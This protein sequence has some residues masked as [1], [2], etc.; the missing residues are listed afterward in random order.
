M[1]DTHIKPQPEV[2]AP[3]VQALIETWG[4]HMPPQTLAEHA[5]VVAKYI[6]PRIGDV[7]VGECLATELDIKDWVKRPQDGGVLQCF[8][9]AKP[10]SASEVSRVMA[11]HLRIAYYESIDPGLLH[12]DFTSNQEISNACQRHNALLLVSDTG[13]PVLVFSDHGELKDFETYTHLGR[14][15][16][17]LWRTYQ[18]NLRLGLTNL[19]ALQATSA[20]AVPSVVRGDEAQKK[21]QYAWSGASADTDA[22]R[23]LAKLLNACVE[24]GY[25]DLDITMGYG[26]TG[27][28]KYRIKGQMVNAHNDIA[29]AQIEEIWRFVGQR[30]GANPQGGRI[31]GP[32]NGSMIYHCAAG[33]VFVRASL[34]PVDIGRPDLESGSIALRLFPIETN[35]AVTLEANNLPGIAI[36][37]IA[38]AVRLNRGIVLV[39]GPTGSGKSTTIAGALELHH[40]LFGPSKK[41]L[42]VEDPIER[43]MPIV[44]QVNVS[45]GGNVGF[46]EVTKAFLRHDPDL[47][48][49]GE[50]RDTE[51]AAS[52]IRAAA[53]GHFVLTTFHATDTVTGYKEIAD[54]LPETR[55]INFVESLNLIFSQR[56]VREVCPRCGQWSEITQEE[57]DQFQ[58][59]CEMYA[60][61]VHEPQKFRRANTQGC[62][63]CDFTGFKGRLPIFES[64]PVTRQVKNLMRAGLTGI[65]DYEAIASHRT[66][67]LY[68]SGLE[69]VNQGRLELLEI[70]E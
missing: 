48:F 10:Q 12:P 43:W 17:P 23:V 21:S 9:A 25:N 13:A 34:I 46:A 51:V 47:I 7:L 63:H 39:V 41:R 52:A 18:Q 66:V 30:S 11:I 54:M 45:E 5:C 19:R 65:Y 37:D 57:R 53:T 32:A 15:S 27:T 62:Q 36:R 61:K 64:L 6:M 35:K 28:A 60:L 1:S 4:W 20:L 29:T 67:D 33:S 70:F 26:G 42:S 31:S 69:L 58:F 68:T 16:D 55:R 2:Q 24:G 40:R 44:T 22:Q 8:I 56:L 14:I 49:V 50:V 38:R 3:H 59:F